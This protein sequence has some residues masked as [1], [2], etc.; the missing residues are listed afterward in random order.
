MG[1][2]NLR[3]N[4][5]DKEEKTEKISEKNNT[6]HETKI[7]EES[8]PE[9]KQID[10]IVEKVIAHVMSP[11]YITST[12]SEGLPDYYENDFKKG[13]R[14]LS[15]SKKYNFYLILLKNRLKQYI[16]KWQTITHAPCPESKLYEV[17]EYAISSIAS[18]I[19]NP[20]IYKFQKREIEN[21]IRTGKELDS[22]IG[23]FGMNPEIDA[24]FYLERKQKELLE[25]TI[26][27]LE[28][29]VNKPIKYGNVG[30]IKETINF[31]NEFNVFANKLRKEKIDEITI[32]KLVTRM[33]ELK[34]QYE[35][36]ISNPDKNL[37]ERIEAQVLLEYYEQI[38]KQKEEEE[39]QREKEID[40]LIQETSEI[41]VS[42]T[43]ENN[44]SSIKEDVSTLTWLKIIDGI[45]G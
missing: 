24:R 4:N 29:I 19:S 38:K 3:K 25:K 14:L 17:V 28:S 41:G 30:N 6:E 42:N 18:D 27:K 16:I 5:K 22:S 10:Q 40:V 15:E 43:L 45:F 31:D 34:K 11:N 26:A 44:I 1:F 39:K 37:V 13:Q 32:F 36:V 21:W 33:G 20:M 12:K 8:N 2:W 35:T 9:E 23:D 7:E